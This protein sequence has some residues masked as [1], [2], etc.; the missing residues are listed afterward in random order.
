MS[1]KV[2]DAILAE[3]DEQMAPLLPWCTGEPCIL[4]PL[5]KVLTNKAHD[6]AFITMKDLAVAFRG[7]TDHAPR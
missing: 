2:V 7:D 5:D 1:D 3:R 6:L 4:I